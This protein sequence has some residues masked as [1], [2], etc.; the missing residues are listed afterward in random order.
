MECGVILIM[1]L[2]RCR[3][4]CWIDSCPQ[5]THT[6]PPPLDRTPTLFI[7]LCSSPLAPLSCWPLAVPSATIHPTSY[8]PACICTDLTVSRFSRSPESP[9][10]LS[11]CVPLAVC[12]CLQDN[13]TF[14]CFHGSISMSKLWTVWENQSLLFPQNARLHRSAFVWSEAAPE[15][16]PTQEMMSAD[17]RRYCLA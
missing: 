16:G 17:G 13:M 9:W 4:I 15:L 10:P 6:G 7:L 8:P 11:C 5:E 2:F 1:F 14:N 3:I 12:A